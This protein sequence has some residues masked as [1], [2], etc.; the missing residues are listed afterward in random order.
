MVEMRDAEAAADEDIEAGLIKVKP[1][2]LGWLV[3]WVRL[4]ASMRVK[5][6]P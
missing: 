3:G 5:V 6:S 2:W 1:G 4:C